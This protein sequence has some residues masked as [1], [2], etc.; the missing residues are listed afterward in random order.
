LRQKH[1]EAPADPKAIEVAVIAAGIFAVL[2][3]AAAGADE[4]PIAH[5]TASSKPS[6]ASN[7]KIAAHKEATRGS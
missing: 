3:A 5:E 2:G 1:T 4:R 6:A 7:W